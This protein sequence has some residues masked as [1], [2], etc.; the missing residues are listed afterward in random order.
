MFGS[1]LKI[2]DIKN[3]LYLFFAITLLECS[4]DDD[5]SQTF[6]EKHDGVL[7]LKGGFYNMRMYVQNLFNFEYF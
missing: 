2:N 5:N 3:L 1:K 4:S 7:L 6:L